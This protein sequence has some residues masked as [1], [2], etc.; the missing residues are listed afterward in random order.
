MEFPSPSRTGRATPQSRTHTPSS[1]GKHRRHPSSDKL[2]RKASVRSVNRSP[3]PQDGPRFDVPIEFIASGRPQ[4]PDLPVAHAVQQPH[5]TDDIPVRTETAFSEA[6]TLVRS[7]S[8]HSRTS[9]A[10]PPLPTDFEEPIPPTALRSIFPQYNHSL[11][12]DRQEYYP[13]QRSPTHIPHEII[14]RQP[15]SPSGVDGGRGPPPLRSPGYDERHHHSHH[16]HDDHSIPAPYFPPKSGPSSTQEYNHNER[17]NLPH[18]RFFGPEPDPEISGIDELRGLWK[19]ANGWKASFSEGQSYTMRVTVEKDAPVYNLLAA[20]GIPFYNLRLDPRANTSYVTLSRRD[21]S[22]LY[23]PPKKPKS[24]S[25]GSHV[26]STGGILSPVS[27]MT[28]TS[29]SI[30]TGGKGWIESLTT[31]IEEPERRLL[32]NDGLVA[33]LYPLQAQKMALNRPD[34]ELAVIQAERECARL[35]FDSDSGSNYLVHPALAT[36]FRISIDRHAAQLRNE[37]VLEHVESPR[38]LARLVRDGTGGG[39]LEVDTNVAARVD[40][41][42]VMDIAVTALLIIANE[43]EKERKIEI[44]EPPPPPP[45]VL[46]EGR[47]S[48]SR[49]SIS[50]WRSKRAEEKRAGSSA[51][52]KFESFEVDIESQTSSLAKMALDE[53]DKLPAGVRAIVKLI[54]FFFKVVFWAFMLLFKMLTAVLKGLNKCC[55]E[56]DK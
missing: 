19:V 40:A 17:S 28:P 47:R 43:D 42:Y 33:L 55:G 18:R 24:S 2:Q 39:F 3:Q 46:K 7:Q 5:A 29:P 37:Y 30:N 54:A 26:P 9:L 10:K 45:A 32:P 13:T 11:P 35:V 14:S 48:N 49:L 44:F 38:H 41:V 1:P 36:P 52:R 51:G 53:K 8:N 20:N 31:V 23:K 12:P 6:A 34:D 4:T 21:P 16:H 25:L 15:Y 56:N 22:K 50:S 27:P